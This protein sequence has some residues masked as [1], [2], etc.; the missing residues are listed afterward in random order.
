MKIRFFDPDHVPYVVGGLAFLLF[1][2]AIIF[3]S[4]Q[5]DRREAER[6][7]VIAS[8]PAQTADAITKYK[9]YHQ[10]YGKRRPWGKYKYELRFQM[11]G[12][13]ARLYSTNGARWYETDIGDPVIVTYHKGPRGEIFVVDWQLKN[14]PE[15]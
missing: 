11:Q 10:P 9:E 13:I 15:K 12:Q 1:I 7:R 5:A 2:F 8:T 6:L 4:H 3:F 14:R